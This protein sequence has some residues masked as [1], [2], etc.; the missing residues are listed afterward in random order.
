MEQLN[1]VDDCLLN[2]D[3][4]FKIVDFGLEA[5]LAEISNSG[6]HCS[7][8]DESGEEMESEHY[9]TVVFRLSKRSI[10]VR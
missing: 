2:A 10:T 6:R 9:Q 3:D 7:V 5:H 8:C 1:A 4:A